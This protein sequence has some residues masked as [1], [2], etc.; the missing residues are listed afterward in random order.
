MALSTVQLAWMNTAQLAALTGT[1]DG[2][3]LYTPLVLDMN[4]DGISTLNVADGVQFD[5]LATGE[6]VSTG[7]AAPT[8][9]L[10]VRDVNGDGVIGSGAE[11]FGEATVL[12]DGQKAQDGYQALAA[13][14][15]NGDGSINNADEAYSSLS[16]WTDANSDGVSQA[17]ELKS[18]EELGI[19]S[20]DLNAQA[21]SLNNNGNWVGLVSSFT[22]VDG[23]TQTM[24]DVWFKVEHG[25]S[26]MQTSSLAVSAGTLAGAL[27][28]FAATAGAG[29]LMS[30]TVKVPG[31]NDSTLLGG[32][33]QQTSGNGWLG[34][35]GS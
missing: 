31:V 16:V 24:A 1:P 19:A 5:L 35:T 22:T 28:Q 15:S 4:G 33:V 14:D 3:G 26:A 8:D 30:A 7:W 21:T 29:T 10:L 13:L 9:G 11:L 25:T 6:K 32:A 27:D 23:A 12:A 17:A 18:L 34:S 2:G 20:L